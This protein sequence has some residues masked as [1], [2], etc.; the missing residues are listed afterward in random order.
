MSTRLIRTAAALAACTLAVAGLG[1]CS[2]GS[3]STGAAAAKTVTWSTWGNPDELK[4]FEQFNKE[5]M[6]RHPDITVK[7]EPV[8]SYADYHSKLNTQLTSKTAPD[9]FYVGDDRIA[10]MVANGVLEPLKDRISK[11]STISLN[12]F[13][14]DIYRVA[15]SDGEVY[16][17]PNDVNPD[18]FWYDKEALKAAGITEDPATLATEGKWTTQKFFEMVDALKNAGMSGAA[19]WN[20]WSTTSSI[21]VSQGGSVYDAS[22]KYVADQ[23]AQASEAMKAWSAKFA[24]GSLLVADEMPSGSDADTLF[25]THKLGFLVQGRYTVGTIEGAG[26]NMS[27]YD[28]V[29]W[30]T[31]EGKNG[32]AGVASSFLAIN[33][34]AANADAAFTFFEEFLSK[35]GQTLRLKDRGNALPSIKGIDSIVT[36][37]GKPAHVA[38]LIEMRDSGF[39]NFPAEAAVPDLSNTIATEIMLPL[40]QG[41]MTSAEALKKA[42]ELVAEKTK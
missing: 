31:P 2:G 28:V 36:E 30:P 14:Q 21:M 17:L 39:S 19:F 7:F 10:A 5:F 42:A 13:S 40:Y 26:L 41:K 37:S 15:M 23:N 11:S 35:D 9:V 33:K 12:D 32:K 4:V 3:G 1:A 38:S 29:G 18:A 27:D 24:D 8:A 22:G 20:Y 6:Q 34:A 25:V 16:A